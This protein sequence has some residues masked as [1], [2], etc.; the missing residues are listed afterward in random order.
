VAERTWEVLESYRTER[1]FRTYRATP[2][3]GR[4]AEPTPEVSA[5]VLAAL[6]EAGRIDADRHAA[7]W[8]L[9]CSPPGQVTS[10]WW[11]TPWQP[12]ALIAA[13][14][15][16]GRPRRTTDGIRPPSGQRDAAFPTTVADLAA[17]LWLGSLSGW[18]PDPMVEELAR[19]L[20]SDGGWRGDTTVLVPG[21]RE[22]DD[23]TCTR[24]A[25]GVFTT[26][27]VL[28][29][30]SAALSAPAAQ[31]A[32]AA[33]STWGRAQSRR[34]ERWDAEIVHVSRAQGV[35]PALA[36]TTFRA[37]TRESLSGAVDWPSSQRSVLAA[38][39]PVE[40]SA[41]GRAGVRFTT[42]VGDARLPVH[43]RVRAGLAAVDRAAA[44]LDLSEGWAGAAPL[45]DVLTDRMLPVPEGTRFWLWAGA[46]LAPDRP[47]TLKAYLSLHAGDVDGWRERRTAALVA[48]G[49]P[50]SGTVWAALRC[51]Y[52]VSWG[53]EI[54][55][56]VVPDGRWGIKVYDELDRWR[57]DVVARLLD[58]CGIPAVASDL[59]PEIP[60]VLRASTTRPRRSGVALRVDPL[61]GE[62]TEVTT[63]VA[64]PAPLAGRD[65]LTERVLAWLDG[66]GQPTAPLR[67]L[68]DVHAHAWHVAPP[69]ERML[70]LVTRTA[71]RSGTSATVYVRPAPYRP[72]STALTSATREL[73]LSR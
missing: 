47:P 39:Q 18:D 26:A 22:G 7:L 53:H 43:A 6:A 2:S 1:G 48:G 67:A 10:Q 57:P 70:S 28:Y 35:D 51:L 21:Q 41:T 9:W 12:S 13:T 15:P 5:V 34:D 38:G 46:D 16:G 14:R 36:L 52:G 40:Y 55:V 60:G 20:R 71:S 64:F 56:G 65:V 72:A 17:A 68:V 33:S 54:G 61:S 42:E 58:L 49:V 63:A 44:L 4:W 25:R 69:A 8:A 30:A 23:D 29:A 37:L 31:R 11:P 59:A 3:T 66:L 50:A 73:D 45:V 32:P 24:D 19:R 27:T 62:V